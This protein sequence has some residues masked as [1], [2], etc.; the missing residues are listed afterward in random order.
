MS[1][2]ETVQR[3]RDFGGWVSRKEIKLSEMN[4]FLDLNSKLKMFKGLIMNYSLFSVKRNF[5]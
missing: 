4:F 5:W 2:F 1:E 3:T